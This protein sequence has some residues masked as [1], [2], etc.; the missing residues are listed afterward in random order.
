MTHRHKHTKFQ[1]RMHTFIYILP[2]LAPSGLVCQ[3]ASLLLYDFAL[4]LD[5]MLLHLQ[6]GKY[7]T[8]FIQQNS[9]RMAPM[10]GSA[11]ILRGR[12]LNPGLPR[13]RRNTNHYTTAECDALS[14]IPP[15]ARIY[16]TCTRNICDHVLLGC[17][18]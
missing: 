15:P 5:R 1:K 18:N 16:A 12:E 8:R 4:M 2:F 3:R 7:R 14:K 6:A 9:T 17:V 11:D 13:D 10:W